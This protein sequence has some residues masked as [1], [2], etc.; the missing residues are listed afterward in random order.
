M[1]SKS[2][3]CPF[4]RGIVTTQQQSG[5][6]RIWRVQGCLC[7]PYSIFRIEFERLHE[8]PARLGGKQKRVYALL[9]ERYHRNSHLPSPLLC[10]DQ[11]PPDDFDAF[12]TISVDELLHTW[13]TTLS[14][15]V[16]RGL[17]NLINHSMGAGYT[18]EY[19]P[20]KWDLLADDT[21]VS[22]F[23]LQMMRERDWVEVTEDGEYRKTLLIRPNGWARF[24]ELARSTR[25]ENPVFVAMW[26]GGK[27]KRDTMSHLYERSIEPAIEAAGFRAKR[28]DTDEH[29]EP[30]M[31]RIIEDIRKCPF[32]VAELS[33][34][35]N[36]VYYEAGF[37]RGLGKEVIHCSR[38]NHRPH[39]D[40]SGINLVK[41]KDDEHLQRRLRDRILGV[42]GS[43]PFEEKA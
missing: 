25:P 11:D 4:C 16:D 26:F 18:I 29:N 12:T 39:F 30:I 8:N 24:E 15:R 7:P 17:C 19:D 9:R 35:N 27:D 5:Y 1:A 38:E 20:E 3:L 37:A 36:G 14:E 23:V 33:D 34:D 13:P 6:H 42:M 21:N 31:D 41:W 28:S 10:V 22:G 32:L 40:V 43:G 2:I